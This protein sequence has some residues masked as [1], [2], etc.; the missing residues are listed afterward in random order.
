MHVMKYSEAKQVLE[1]QEKAKAVLEAYQKV[2]S[3]HEQYGFQSRR[4]FIKALQEIDQAAGGKG[5][6]KSKG[7][8]PRG[9][10]PDVIDQIKSL[11]AD[12]KTNAEIARTTGVSP[13]TVGKYVK[14][15][16]GKA[17]ARPASTA[18]A[19]AA[20]DRQTTP[21]KGRSGQRGLP[22]ETIDRIRALKAE[23]KTN[24]DISRTV[25][26]SA[27]TVAKYVKG[28]KG[29]AK[30]ASAKRKGGRAKKAK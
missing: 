1:Q 19:P 16:A 10:S 29:S 24:V 9:L 15:V 3:A 25:G 18:A 12:G 13:L 28:Q 6:A 2:A 26:V 20:S 4:E 22:G 27:L 17:G 7:R 21:A 5:R 23:G 8:G 30:K 11:K 14:G